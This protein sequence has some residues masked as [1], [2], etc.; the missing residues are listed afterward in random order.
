M[1]L[2]KTFIL[3]WKVQLLL[4][5]LSPFNFCYIGLSVSGTTDPLKV[6]S[7]SDPDLN[8]WILILKDSY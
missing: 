8:R 3:S 4:Q 5:D 7:K 1:K 2:Q 6:V